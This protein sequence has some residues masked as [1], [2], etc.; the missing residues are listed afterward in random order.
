MSIIFKVLVGFEQ[1]AIVGCIQKCVRGI[2]F[3]ECEIV[4]LMNRRFEGY[5]HYPLDQHLLV[6]IN[7]N[8]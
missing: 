8:T 6:K 2:I 1:S 5:V 3:D 4:D 7:L